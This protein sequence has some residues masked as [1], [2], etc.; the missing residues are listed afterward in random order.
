MGDGAARPLP[1]GVVAL[2]IAAVIT[3][4]CSVNASSDKERPAGPTADEV[5]SPPEMTKAEVRDVIADAVD[6]TG[7]FVATVVRHGKV[8]RQWFGS[9]SARQER[10][11]VQYQGPGMTGRDL[12]PGD[13]AVLTVVM[14]HDVFA[15][16]RPIGPLPTCWAQVADPESSPVDGVSPGFPPQ[17][18][19]LESVK[20]I[21][22]VYIAGR[23]EAT[24]PLRLAMPLV[25]PELDQR[26]DGQRGDEPVEIEVHFAKKTL[27]G[28]SILPGAVSNAARRAGLPFTQRELSRLAGEQTVIEISKLGEDVDLAFPDEAPRVSDAS[29]C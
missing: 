14:G 13:Y 16:T 26:L 18:S 24:L 27:S 25:D 29:A 15:A 1:Q 9:Y 19:A 12:G 28:W 21:S 17:I 6:G 23:A 8:H 11:V 5:R 20:H 22:P 7:E 2:M 4:G 3:T 10:A